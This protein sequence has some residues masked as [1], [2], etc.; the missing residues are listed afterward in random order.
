MTLAAGARPC[1]TQLAAGDMDG[2][3][4]DELIV[5][6]GAPYGLY[7]FANN[8]SWALLHPLSTEALIVGDLDGGG[9]ADVVIDFGAPGLWVFKNNTTWQLLHSLSP[10]AMT[11]GRLH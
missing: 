10:E 4:K 6:F 3:G 5:D 2:N 7:I 1:A 9:R 11:L 8:T